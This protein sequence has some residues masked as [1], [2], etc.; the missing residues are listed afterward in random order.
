MNR[1]TALIGFLG[2]SLSSLANVAELAAICQSNDL[3]VQQKANLAKM[4]KGM[5]AIVPTL[6][7][8]LADSQ[9]DLQ[10]KLLAYE[11]ATK[12]KFDLSRCTT[13]SQIDNRAAL[14]QGRVAD[15]DIVGSYTKVVSEPEAIRDYCTAQFQYQNSK[16]LPVAAM[17]AGEQ[18]KFRDAMV[19]LEKHLAE[20]RT[21]YQQRF[22]KPLDDG[23]CA[24]MGLTSP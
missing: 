4:R 17:Q 13:Q 8:G 6:E 15:K 9:A 16:R 14:Q 18:K 11:K 2:V 24:K 10:Q 22:K 19:K 23:E 12:K 7:K 20:R 3:I 1:L 5:P 21:A